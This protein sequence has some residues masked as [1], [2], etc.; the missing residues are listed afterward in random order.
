MSFTMYFEL[1]DRCLFQVVNSL[2]ILNRMLSYGWQL[3]TEF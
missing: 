1:N 2:E 3:V